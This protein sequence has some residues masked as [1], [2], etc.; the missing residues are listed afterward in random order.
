MG[1]KINGFSARSYTLWALFVLCSPELHEIRF[2]DLYIEMSHM[3]IAVI[4]FKLIFVYKR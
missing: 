1:G 4:D 2:N 3:L